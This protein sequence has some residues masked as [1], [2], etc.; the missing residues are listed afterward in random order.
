MAVPES[1][2]IAAATPAGPSP[3]HAKHGRGN[4][5]CVRQGP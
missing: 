1:G 5:A 4:R 2:P 3:V